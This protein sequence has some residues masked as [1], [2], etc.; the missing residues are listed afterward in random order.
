MRKKIDT[1]ELNEPDK[2]QLFF[3]SARTF[4]EKHKTRIYAG[5][6]V[7]VFILV[8][9]GGWYLYRLNY[10]ENAR[11]IYSKIYETAQKAQ[12]PDSDQASIKE[13]KDLIIQYP[14]SRSAVLA[15]YR[16]GNLYYNRHEIDEAILAYKD[17]LK[18]SPAESD[19]VTLAYHA[20]GACHEAKK[21]FKESIESFEYAM[22]TNTA[23]SFEALNYIGIARVHEAMNNPEKAVEFYRKALGKTTD[24]LT[25]LYLKRKISILG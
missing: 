14:Q 11:K 24:P 15:R 5:A 21:N 20:L 25:T 8:I 18:E 7:F 23:S 17:F 3:L 9:V 6:G 4:A 22:K 10:E 1:K 16:L 13:Y 19:L 12:S 2:L